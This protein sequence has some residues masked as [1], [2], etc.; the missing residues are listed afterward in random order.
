MVEREDGT[1]DAK[2]FM[3]KSNVIDLVHEY[4]PTCINVPEECVGSVVGAAVPGTDGAFKVV[5]VDTEATLAKVGPR[6]SVCVEEAVRTCFNDL[7]CRGRKNL[8]DIRFNGRRSRQANCRV[9]FVFVDVLEVGDGSDV[10]GLGSPF[11]WPSCTGHK[12][13]TLRVKSQ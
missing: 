13:Q 11:V 12:L 5:V 2:I 1:Y 3:S 9:P 4:C 7:V 6:M 8:V 10:V